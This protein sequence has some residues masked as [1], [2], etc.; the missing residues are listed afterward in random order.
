MYG[1]LGK[2]QKNN[3]IFLV[4]R[5]WGKALR[6]ILFFKDLKNL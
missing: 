5:G 2:P 3:G 4:A 6:K 1:P